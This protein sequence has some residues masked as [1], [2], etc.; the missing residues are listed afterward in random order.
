MERLWQNVSSSPVSNVNR[1]PADFDLFKERIRRRIR[2]NKR[3]RLRETPSTAE[4][5]GRI[6]AIILVIAVCAQ[7]VSR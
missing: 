5:A 2:Q 7:A 3:A 6:A 4:I 1:Y